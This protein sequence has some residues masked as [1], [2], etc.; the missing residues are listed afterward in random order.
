VRDN[1]A[2]DKARRTMYFL[3]AWESGEETEARRK[4][5]GRGEGMKKGEEPQDT[6]CLPQDTPCF[7]RLRSR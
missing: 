2:I 7:L 5:E 1:E 4:R 3:V 6:P